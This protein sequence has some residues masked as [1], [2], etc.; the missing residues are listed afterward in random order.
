LKQLRGS[1]V[2]E[3]KTS[4]WFDTI[5]AMK[6]VGFSLAERD[7]ILKE[8]FLLKAKEK[9]KVFKGRKK[10]FCVLLDY[11]MQYWDKKGGAMKGRLEL[12][13]LKISPVLDKRNTVVALRLNCVDGKRS[14]WGSLFFKAG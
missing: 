2:D 9:G 10:R 11:Q 3:C 6:P 7:A 8:G 14:V 13:G 12:I 4:L 5:V 1:A